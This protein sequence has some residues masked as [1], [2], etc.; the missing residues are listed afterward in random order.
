LEKVIEA[1]E[2]ERKRIARDLHDEF[3]Q[4]LTALTMNLQSAM[5]N[6][7]EEMGT[8]KQQ[9]AETQALTTQ[10]LEETGQWIR[11]LRPTVLDDLGLV[12]AVRWY[13]ESR[14]EAAGT[15]V[16]VEALGFK[17]RLPAG[18]ETALFRIVQEA[19]NNIAK[20]ARA[21]QAHIRLEMSD[22]SITASVGDDGVGFD[23]ADALTL[24]DG[25]RG[26]GLLGMRERAA[27]LGGTLAIDSH[28]GHGTR[29][30]VE[31]PWTELP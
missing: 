31:V 19:V 22:T 2:E 26:I 16:Y 13:A 4:T 29:I 1:Q 18:I 6:L 30:R 23:S 3:A 7:P 10:T 5:L 28:V 20:H 8:L 14:L 12:P 25:M 17:R 15:R 21:R 9:L 27:L 11:D 24:K